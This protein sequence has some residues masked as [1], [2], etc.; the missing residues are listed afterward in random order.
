MKWHAWAVQHPGERAEVAV[1]LIGDKGT[2]KNRWAECLQII[3]GEHSFEVSSQEQV[4]GKFNAHMQNC[5][6]FLVNEAWWG[7]DKKAVGRLQSM[8]TEKFLPIEPK[9]FNMF[10]AKNCLHMEM[11]A[12]PGWVIPAGKY[13][14]RYAIFKVSGHRRGDKAY[15]RALQEEIEGDGPAA[16]LWEL[17]RMD[18]GDWHPRDIPTSLLWSN[19]MQEQVM[20]TLPPWERWWFLLLQEGRVPNALLKMNP[21]KPSTAYS[22]ALLANARDRVPAL[23]HQDY[24][25]LREFMLSKGC[26]K[27]EGERG[28]GWA[29]PVLPDCRKAWDAEYGPQDWSLT[30]HWAG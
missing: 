23:Q 15:F 6:L 8:I 16:L 22:A 14:R 1:V 3:F 29:L 13:E 20:R 9:G 11:L 2:G 25:T 24:F 27:Y 21:P 18:L 4:A 30:A 10:L 26:T 19:A 7:G 5:V 17:Q 28:N 12:E